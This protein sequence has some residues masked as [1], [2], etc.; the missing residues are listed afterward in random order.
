MLR[1]IVYENPKEWD[2]PLDQV[3]SAYNDS[4]NRSMCMTP[5]LC[6]VWDLPKGSI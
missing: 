2:L 1:S 3:D 4:P 6:C 5:F